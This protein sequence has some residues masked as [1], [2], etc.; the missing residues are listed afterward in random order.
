MAFTRSGGRL[1]LALMLFVV[2][3]P[4]QAE[5]NGP[6]NTGVVN[7]GDAATKNACIECCT[8]PAS[9]VLTIHCCPLVGPCTVTN[10]P[11]GSV[12]L[13]LNETSGGL[14]LQFQRVVKSDAVDI[15]MKL[16]FLNKTFPRPLVLKA[17]M[18]GSDAKLGAL[19]FP[20]LFLGQGSAAAGNLQLAGYDVQVAGI[21]PT[22]QSLF[23]TEACAQFG[24]RLSRGI[25]G[26]LSA[27]LPEE[28]T[29]FVDATTALGWPACGGIF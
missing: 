14:K 13:K 24:T 26:A 19:L 29:P 9:C 20:V 16:Q 7:C 12:Q 15:K 3:A 1:I 6:N 17:R 21:L 27:S 4:A 8:T 10:K 23:P 28:L 5:D 18:T 2:S 11:S 22:C 25:H